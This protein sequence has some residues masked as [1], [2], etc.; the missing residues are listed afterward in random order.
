MSSVPKKDGQFLVAYEQHS[1]EYDRDGVSRF[2]GGIARP[3][4]WLRM[5]RRALE[6]SGLPEWQ[7]NLFREIIASVTSSPA[8]QPKEMRTRK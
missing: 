4:V 5:F 8:P 7:K 2:L 3:C 6:E 1:T